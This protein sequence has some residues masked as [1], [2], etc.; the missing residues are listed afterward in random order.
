MDNKCIPEHKRSFKAST[1]IAAIMI[2]AGP[3][4]GIMGGSIFLYMTVTGEMIWWEGLLFCVLG[5]V[6]AAVFGYLL[7]RFLRSMFAVRAIRL[8]EGE[9]LEIVTIT[10]K[11][12]VAALPNNVEY[13]VPDDD[14][15]TVAVR[16]E[17]RRFV[18]DS[19]EFKDG[20]RVREFF[21]TRLQKPKP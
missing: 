20:E 12:F 16:V 7:L 21:K 3:A 1:T 8:L 15:L 6:I 9:R 11:T 18:I 13:V 10:G 4:V 5:F 19:A 2:G 17:G 14:G